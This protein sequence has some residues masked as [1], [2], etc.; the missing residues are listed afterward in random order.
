MSSEFGNLLDEDLTSRSLSVGQV[1]EGTV[2]QINEDGV[3]VDIGAKSEGHLELD[4]ITEEELRRL[5]I[6]DH[7]KVKIVRH[8][9]GEFKLSKKSVD[10][11]EGWTKLQDDVANSREIEIVVR[12]KV[13]NG[14]MA[15]AYGIVE[16]FIH[17]TNFKGRPSPGQAFRASV[18]EANRKA[19]KL[20]FTRRDIMQ[21][22]EQEALERDYGQ[23]L[24]G[25]VVEGVVERLSPYG[26]FVKITNSV[27][28]LLH[29][30]EFSYEHVKKPS[31]VLKPG[32]VVPVKILQID[33]EKNKV[34][35]SR[36]QAMKDPLMLM[37]PGEEMDGTVE[38]V[39]EFGVFVRLE[40]GVTGLVHVSELSHKRFG[41]PSEIIKPGET[42]RVKVLRVQPE[43]RRV[44]LSA[45]ATERDPWSEVYSHFTNGQQVTGPV[46]Q[47][48]QSGVVMELEGGFEAFVP[49][50]EMSEE[51]IKHPS[52]LYKEGDEITGHV[53]SID[54]AKRRIRVSVRRQSEDTG[55]PMGGSMGRSAEP[56][57]SDIRPTAGKV[58]LGD[59]LAGKLDLTAAA[60]KDDAPQA[61]EE[62]ASTP[63]AEVEAPAVDDAPAAAA[64]S[65]PYPTGVADEAVTADE[66][67]ETESSPGREDAETTETSVPSDVV[68][69]GGGQDSSDA[70][71]SEPAV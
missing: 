47:I 51:R 53:L 57:V 58:T 22:E 13:K 68:G 29:I 64:E 33:R 28:G 36:K 23:L 65:D 67:G 39:A 62:V 66:P 27:T 37:L 40:N 30:S 71:D 12:E 38:S 56:M 41:H 60:K 52:D 15:E 31:E 50:S 8:A 48:L 54:S 6:G 43:D 32:D 42:L 10:Y 49:I 69:E 17:H 46:T 19:R 14:Y 26:A 21:K 7:I 3:F 35:L 34:S 4:Q 70:P 25:M 59:I 9:D 24:E 1:V 5:Q 63:A 11:D 44:S 61:K 16:G 18:L 2:V 20:V 45:K 55:R